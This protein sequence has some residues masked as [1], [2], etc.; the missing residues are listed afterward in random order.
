M[1]E[2]SSRVRNHPEVPGGVVQFRSRLTVSVFLFVVVA[3]SLCLSNRAFAQS[4]TQIGTL[5]NSI[6]SAYFWDAQHGV[7]AGV[8]FIYTYRSGVWTQAT[9]PEATGT[10]QAL[11]YLDQTNHLYAT[12]GS[13]D[14][15]VSTDSGASWGLTGQNIIGANDLYKD[16]SGTYHYLKERGTAPYLSGTTFVRA[17]GNMCV[18]A[19]DDVAGFPPFSND[20]GATWKGSSG[21]G[22]FSG[23][24]GVYA[25]SCRGFIFATGEQGNGVRTLDGGMTWTTVPGVGSRDIMDGADGVMYWQSNSGVSRSTDQGQGWTSIAGP[26]SVG[27]DNRV[28]VFGVQGRYCFA[29]SGAAAWLWDGGPT[30]PPSTVPSLLSI[31]DTSG[32]NVAMV[33]LVIKPGGPYTIDLKS[34]WDGIHTISPADTVITTSKLVA[35]TIWYTISPATYT[36]K[37]FFHISATGSGACVFIQWDTSFNVIPIVSAMPNALAVKD[38]F[39]HDCSIASIGVTVKA[40]SGSFPV[41]MTATGDLLHVLSP[42]D[43]TFLTSGTKSTIINYTIKPGGITDSIKLTFHATGQDPCH[44][45]TWDSSFMMRLAPKPASPFAV[46]DSLVRACAIPRIPLLI[47]PPWVPFTFELSED[48]GIAGAGSDSLG[49]V[50]PRDTSVTLTTLQTDT[51]FFTPLPQGPTGSGRYRIHALAM[52]CAAYA[53]DTSFNIGVAPGTLGL[54]VH[55]TTI[56]ACDSVLIPLVLRLTACDSLLIDLF[57]ISANSADMLQIVPGNLWGISRGVNDTLWLKYAPR[58]QGENRSYDIRVKGHFVP[59]GLVLD[60]TMH[61]ALK[62]VSTGTPVSVI[63]PKIALS[64]CTPALVPLTL[65]APPC[66]T[67]RLDSVTF[68]DGGKIVTL[69]NPSLGMAFPGS[70]DT[71]WLQLLTGNPN[72][73]TIG[74]H[75]YATIIE[76]GRSFDTLIYFV[77]TAG[78]DLTKQSI[79][80]ASTL[81][82]S[83]CR[84]SIVPIVLHA[85]PCDSMEFTSCTLTIDPTMTYSTNLAFSQSLAPDGYDTLRIVFP[86]QQLSKTSVIYARIT[87]RIPGTTY[88]FDTTVQVRVKFTSEYA[89]LVS[90]PSAVDLQSVNTCASADTLVYFKNLGCDTLN[91]TGDNTVW[92]PGWSATDPAFPSVLPPDSGFYVRVHI[93]PTVGGILSQYMAY[94]ITGGGKTST[95]EELFLTANGIQGIGTLAIARTS[96]DAGSHPLCNTDTSVSISVSNTGCDTLLL[97]NA[98]LEPATQFA[99]INNGDTVIAP[100]SSHI[101]TIHFSAPVK[102]SFNGTLYFHSASAHGGTPSVDTTILLFASVGDGVKAMS[103]SSNA[104]HFDTTGICDERDSSILI[105]NSGCDTMTVWGASFSSAAI[106]L[107]DTLHFP[108]VLPPGSSARIPFLTQLDTS[109]HQTYNTS[110]LTIT[111]DV[112]PDAAPIEVTRGIDYPVQFSLALT[113]TATTTVGKLVGVQ[114]TK[115]GIFPRGLTSIDFGLVSVN[116]LLTYDSTTDAEVKYL[117]STAPDVDHTEFHYVLR[118]VVDRP[119]LA[120]LYLHTMLATKATTALDLKDVQFTIAGTTNPACLAV[121]DTVG[122]N[123][124]LSLICGNELIT[125]ALLGLQIQ[126]TS[127]EANGSV[128][129]TTIHRDGTS[130]KQCQG[131]VISVLGEVRAQKTIDLDGEANSLDWNLPD[132]TSGTYFLRI[133]ADPNS[134]APREVITRRFILAR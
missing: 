39:V 65:K 11:R 75:V 92:L 106:L 10:F 72:R 87:G 36:G 24:Y 124:H 17:G 35:T 70:T 37:A 56:S 21:V 74:A 59:S 23:G 91:V 68:D 107:S 98:H 79:Q 49:H 45:F 109:V 97:S 16:N 26:A 13:S 118:P 113:N 31:Q 18:I 15:W 90:N 33:R 47:T 84:A 28:F 25:D 128:L 14:V 82:L 30:S 81:S 88:T 67:L 34:V 57:T 121:M 126:L 41:R 48:S 66:Q 129:H 4:W 22:S 40:T 63:P 50:F 60:T 62:A 64:L 78:A 83:N 96:I 44:G 100:N 105:T 89:I 134:A 46:H 2:R 123:F 52:N 19:A 101:Y 119:I 103:I 120:K 117:G 132:L 104:V 38:T 115:S 95:S 93:A 51:V 53:W 85:P 55:G 20:G 6:R 54:F 73:Y 86:P 80:L 130:V 111:T 99:L 110:T 112:Q 61:I 43:T 133:S 8:G 3:Q 7:V 116:D 42:A 5:P 29:S 114:L 108:I 125:D 27:E 122:S 32:C 71:V 58:S 127:I 9:Y 1:D 102:G 76:N 77:A 131:E 94:A 12:S 69:K